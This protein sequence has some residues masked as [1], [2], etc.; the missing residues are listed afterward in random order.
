V[1]VCACWATTVKQPA[2]NIAMKKILFNLN[3]LWFI[4]SGRVIGTTATGNNNNKKQLRFI[5]TG[6]KE[7]YK[8]WNYKKKMNR[9]C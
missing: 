4:I 7:S 3:S 8:H 1:R 5:I 6:K 2:D 9:N